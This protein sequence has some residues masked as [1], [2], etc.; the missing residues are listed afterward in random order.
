METS[1]PEKDTGT[2]AASIGEKRSKIVAMSN[3]Y[4]T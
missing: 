1:A 3:G 4:F 2:S